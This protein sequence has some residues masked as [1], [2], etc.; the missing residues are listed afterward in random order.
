MISPLWVAPALAAVG[1]LLVF[2][3][4]L[5]RVGAGGPALDLMARRDLY[6]LPVLRIVE[7]PDYR[8]HS[9]RSRQYRQ[10]LLRSFGSKLRQ[11]VDDLT[12][13]PSTPSATLYRILFHLAFGWLSL[14]AYV[15]TGRR[16]LRVLLGIELL[17]IRSLA[18]VTDKR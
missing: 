15:W 12:E 2:W 13:S 3:D 14:K 18:D 6:I 5:A 10:F 9:R 11:D 7:S 8:F 1:A 17:L 4:F 16:D